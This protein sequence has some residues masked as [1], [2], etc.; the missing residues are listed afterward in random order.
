[1]VDGWVTTITTALDD[2]KVKGNPLDHRLVRILL[3]EFLDE[4][5][6]AATQRAE[7]EATIKGATSDTE[8]EETEDDAEE[9]WPSR[10]P[11]WRH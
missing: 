4:I 6:E 11:S 1:M 9:R 7:L 8:D 10:P 2:K 3:P 5:Q